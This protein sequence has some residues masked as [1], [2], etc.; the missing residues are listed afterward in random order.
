MR[1]VFLNYS[2]LQL[3]FWIKINIQNAFFFCILWVAL[4]ILFISKSMFF[5]LLITWAP[6]EIYTNK[7]NTRIWNFLSGGKKIKEYLRGC[8]THPQMSTTSGRSLER[9]RTHAR[10]WIRS[11]E[12]WLCAGLDWHRCGSSEVCHILPSR[13]PLLLL[14]LLTP[15]PPHLQRDASQRI[16]RGIH[17]PH[18]QR[19]ALT[20]IRRDIYMQPGLFFGRRRDLM[21]PCQVETDGRFGSW[22]GGG[23]EL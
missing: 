17:A 8:K 19:R 20:C 1:V 10:C 3:P 14:L 21:T 2:Q 6:L 23:G 4:I 16:S 22:G 7:S 12:V 9:Q 15:T 18:D 13:L 5:F 11:G